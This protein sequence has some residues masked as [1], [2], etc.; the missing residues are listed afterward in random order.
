MTNSLVQE[1]VQDEVQAGFVAHVPG[2]TQELKSK[3]KRAAV[4]KLG[5][6]ITEGRAARLVVDSSISNVT[7]NTVLPN[8]MLL[9][10]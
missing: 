5:A 7:A 1:L 6:V 2:G 3:F 9:P 8:H 10:R 4:G